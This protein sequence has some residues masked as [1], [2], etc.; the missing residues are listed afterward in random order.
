M[1]KQILLEGFNKNITNSTLQKGQRV[2]KNDLLRELNVD[3]NKDYIK[4]NSIVV[5]ESLLSEYSCKLEFDNVTKEVIGTHCSCLDFEKNEFSKDNYC[6]K[7][8]VATF[9]SFLKKIDEDE[10]IR[11]KISNNSG[12]KNIKSKGASNFMVETN[13]TNSKNEGIH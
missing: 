8:L 12:S 13:I 10:S 11:S 2:L 9:Y 5:S 4:I 1:I 3:V 6:C 7:H